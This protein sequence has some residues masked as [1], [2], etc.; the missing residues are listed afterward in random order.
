MQVHQLMMDGFMRVPYPE[1]L[2]EG[3][4]R[5]M[6][7]WKEFCNLPAKE[8]QRLSLGDRHKDVGYVLRSGEGLHGDH[9]EFFHASAG[10][11]REVR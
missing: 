2:V 7:S 1:E 6:E 9:K 3:V 5:S 11:P 10:M 4:T 8:K